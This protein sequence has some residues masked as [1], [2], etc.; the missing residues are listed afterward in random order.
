MPSPSKPAALVVLTSCAPCGPLPPQGWLLPTYHRGYWI[1]LK[2]ASPRNFD[3][4]DSTSIPA[5]ASGWK[6]WGPG[7]PDNSMSNELCASASYDM[8]AGSPPTWGWQDVGCGMPLPLMCRMQK[9]QPQKVFTHSS[10]SRYLLN[11]QRMNF[12]RAE[13]FCNVNGGRLASYSSAAEQQAVEQF[14]VDGGMLLPNFARHSTYWMGLRAATWPRFT[15]LDATLPAP[16]AASFINWG[17]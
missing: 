6:N 11:T 9:P 16:A 4:I 3:W 14:Y 13:T 10:G 2:A 7:Q 5:L 17:T 12:S 1:G 8:R 15:W